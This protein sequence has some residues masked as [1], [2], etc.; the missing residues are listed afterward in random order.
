MTEPTKGSQA[1]GQE[2]ELFLRFMVEKYGDGSPEMYEF[3]NKRH[4][5]GRWVGMTA[6]NMWQAWIYRAR[7]G[8]A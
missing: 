4:P 7:M 3:F 6:E 2:R 8:G 5:D 1:E